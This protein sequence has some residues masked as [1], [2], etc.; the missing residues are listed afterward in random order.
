[1]N[2]GNTLLY[3]IRFLTPSRFLRETLN[4]AIFQCGVKNR[5]ECTPAPFNYYETQCFEKTIERRWIKVVRHRN[6]QSAV[7]R[8]AQIIIVGYSEQ[9]EKYS[10]LLLL[11]RIHLTG[12]QKLFA[13]ITK[14]IIRITGHSS[15]KIGI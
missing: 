10:H 12:D 9:K 1:M 7:L 5:K 13:I 6:E 4:Y 3:D 14:L 15:L 2:V 11:L 8:P